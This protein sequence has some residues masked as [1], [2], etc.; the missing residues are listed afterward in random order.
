ML[1]VQALED[2]LG[3]LVGIAIGDAYERKAGVE[4]GADGRV[5]TDD[6]AVVIDL[7]DPD[8]T[9]ELAS[10]FELW[11]TGAVA[12]AFAFALGGR[13]EL[14][15]AAVAFGLEVLINS[16]GRLLTDIT[17]DRSSGPFKRA[18]QPAEDLDDVAVV[19]PDAQLHGKVPARASTMDRARGLET[20]IPED[21]VVDVAG[22]SSK[23]RSALPAATALYQETAAS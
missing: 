8:G 4:K 12:L 9:A 17:H 16:P 10:P 7:Q 3:E 11:T 15:P 19:D 14:G 6:G 20:R 2:F 21:L 23:G 22:G 1:S 13:G 18:L 5:G